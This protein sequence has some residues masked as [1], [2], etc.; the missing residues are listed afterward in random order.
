M[1][2]ATDAQFAEEMKQHGVQIVTDVDVD[3]F[4]AKAR[5]AIANVPGITPGIYDKALAAMAQ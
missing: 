5:P 2:T 1:S 3:A 4:A